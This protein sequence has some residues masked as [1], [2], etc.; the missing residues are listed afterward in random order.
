MDMEGNSNHNATTTQHRR[1]SFP[2]GVSTP[3][4]PSMSSNNATIA[5]SM[6]SNLLSG[7]RDVAGGSTST[8]S[9]YDESDLL[10]HFLGRTGTGN[11][12]GSAG[13]ARSFAANGNE[14]G[15]GLSADRA[16][17]ILDDSD[18]DES[19]VNANGIDDFAF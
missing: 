16:L 11:G 13:V 15:A 6:N 10:D 8:G 12:S 1:S 14:E 2:N 5:T 17:E 9:V 7:S 3:P 19:H 4:P 18:D